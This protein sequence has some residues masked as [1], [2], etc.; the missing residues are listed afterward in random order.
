MKISAP[1]IVLVV[2]VYVTPFSSF[3]PR[4]NDFP[5][6]Y[7]LSQ[8]WK[9]LLSCSS[10]TYY[11]SALSSLPSAQ[12]ILFIP[13]LFSFLICVISEICVN[14]FSISKIQIILFIPYL[15]SYFICVISEICVNPFSI[16]KI[17]F[18]LFI[19][20]LLSYFICAICEICVNPFSISKI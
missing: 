1:R 10:P 9:S 17:L 16:S 11:L 8:S 2:T 15:F 14:P 5:H 12:I 20:Y 4:K 19:P 13:Y 7:Y 18:I 6:R 3:N